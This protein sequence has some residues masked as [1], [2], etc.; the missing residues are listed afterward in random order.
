MHTNGFT[1]QKLC[2][3]ASQKDAFLRYQFVSDVSVFSSDMLIFIDETGA[4]RRN[5]VR[6]YGYS[7]R[8]KPM[9]NQVLLTRGER[10]SAI[11]CISTAGLIDVKTVRGTTDGDTFYDFIGTHLLP[12][13]MPF[14][15]I[16]PHS[17]VILD[18]CSIHHTSSITRTI[19]SLVL[20]L[21]PT[22][23]TLIPLRRHF[24]RKC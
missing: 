17:V 2:T 6:K 20:F 22:H 4:D 23:Q 1:R 11:A 18:N 16:N 3:V 13:L 24:L 5:T 9:K 8:G 14:N 10:I 12:H 19:G 7:I 15:G 21:P